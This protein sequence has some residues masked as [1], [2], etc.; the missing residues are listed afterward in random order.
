DQ[1]QI[2]N[3]INVTTPCSYKQQK[4]ITRKLV[5]FIIQYVQLLHIFQSKEQL[6]FLLSDNVIAVHLTTDL[7]TAK[8]H[9]SYLGITA[10][11]LTAEFEFKEAQLTCNHLPYSY[12]S[13]VISDELSKI[14]ED[15]G[16]SQKV[17]AVATD[18]RTNMLKVTNLLSD[19]YDN[20]I[21]HQSCAA[22]IL[23][24]L[25]LEGHHLSE[26]EHMNLLDVLMDVK[27]RWSL[28]YYIWKRILK[29]YN[30]MK[31]VYI[32]LLSKNDR[33][34]RKE[35]EKLEH[36]CLSLEEREFFQQII[37]L[38]EPIEHI[39][40]KMCGA[41]YPTINLI[42]LYMDLFK[43]FFASR[44]EAEETFD[45]YL[46]LIYCSESV[47]N[48][49]NNANSDSDDEHVLLGGSRQQ[50]QHVYHQFK[51]RMRNKYHSIQKHCKKEKS[52]SSN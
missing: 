37:T 6:Y 25:V 7:W 38:L 18:N 34:S 5:E 4:E 17:F 19:K 33:L 27:T 49:E 12:T 15:W 11:W 8:S 22:H 2:T 3:Y 39:T 14:I 20:K 23:Q 41:T 1:L 45:T 32:D 9:Y 24:L 28:T 10:T 35:G 43:N 48:N 21:Q 42:N 16:L 40:C 36:L 13:E 26:N 52:H 46:D 30:Y 50:W 31:L 44:K 51:Q 29:L 47:N